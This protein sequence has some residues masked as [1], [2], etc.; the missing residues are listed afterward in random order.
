MPSEAR[1]P[2]HPQHVVMHVVGHLPHEAS[3]GVDEGKTLRHV[4]LAE[5]VGL[6]CGKLRRLVQ[7]AD[8]GKILGLHVW[9]G[10]Y[11]HVL[12]GDRLHVRDPVALFAWRE[13]F[14]LAR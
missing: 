12:R 7:R 3:P 4:E 6:E 9:N 2:G 11:R 8:T 13:P 5:L 10:L 14:A 1:R